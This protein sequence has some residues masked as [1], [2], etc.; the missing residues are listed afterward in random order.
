M[1]K[2]TQDSVHQLDRVEDLA[3][4]AN[5]PI[6]NVSYVLQVLRKAPLVDVWGHGLYEA[7]CLSDERVSRV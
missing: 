4:E 6:A 5:L 3:A 1:N 2:H 7:Y